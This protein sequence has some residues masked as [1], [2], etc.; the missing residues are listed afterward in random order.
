VA[1]QFIRSV[2]LMFSIN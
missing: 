1:H 2:G